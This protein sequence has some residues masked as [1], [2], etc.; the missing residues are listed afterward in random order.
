MH[1]RAYLLGGMEYDSSTVILSYTLSIICHLVFFMALIIMPIIMPSHAPDRDFRP[2]VI[3]VRM[4]SLPP[5]GKASGSSKQIGIIPEKQVIS[6][7]KP[8]KH[9]TVPEKLESEVIAAETPVA[10]RE[11]PET[12]VL[13]QE[14][15]PVS[16]APPKSDVKTD[17]KPTKTV[18]VAP[19]KKKI[20]TS[21]KKKTFKPTKVVKSA[22]A[23]IEKET[24]K[25][26]PKPVAEAID[27]LKNKVGKTEAI[28]RLKSKVGTGES[29]NAKGV[30]GGSRVGNT[31]VLGLI[32]I[33][34]TEISYHI[35]KNWAFNEQLA[36][37]RTDLVAVLVIK[38]MPDGEIRDV[39]FEKKSG[40]NYFDDS[41][42]RAVKKSNPLPQLPKG[43]LRPF[44]NL[45]LIF[46]PSGLKKGL[47]H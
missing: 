11:M 34:R 22:I 29:G 12:Q 21:L 13:K 32:D 23:R 35:E 19:K 14:M 30:P 43:Y 44:Y 37:G 26:R 39:W 38:I 16:E 45:G 42:E 47:L 27:R 8:E 40:N 7:K 24:E 46:T 25:S 2:S 18:S 1:A 10:P 3:N 5:L 6:Q 33:Y 41:A 31:K 17:K 4:V 36:D 28:A 9:A 15:T 20:K